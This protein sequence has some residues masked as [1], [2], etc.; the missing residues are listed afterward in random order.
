MSAPATARGPGNGQPLAYTNGF[1]RTNGTIPKNTNRASWAG[2]DQKLS[3]EERSQ[4][5]PLR[6][7]LMKDL[8]A[9]A[10]EEM[11]FIVNVASVSYQS[12]IIMH[13]FASLVLN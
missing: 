10:E 5:R 13:T 1:A 12:L 2:A 8:V 4:A 7:R 3:S 6:Y 11:R 9:E